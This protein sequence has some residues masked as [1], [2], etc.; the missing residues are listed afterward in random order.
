MKTLKAAHKKEIKDK[1]TA[2]AK[3]IKEKGLQAEKDLKQK[4][5]TQ[6]K[7]IVDY[8][9]TIVMDDKSIKFLEGKVESITKKKEELE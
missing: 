5:E 2:H 7:E 8:K 6:T 4:T 9:N 3:E 1:D